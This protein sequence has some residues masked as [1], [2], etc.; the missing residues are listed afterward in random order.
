MKKDT[1]PKT[2]CQCRTPLLITR[3]KAV[4]EALKGEKEGLETIASFKQ[5]F[6]IPDHV[7]SVKSLDNYKRNEEM[8]Y[9]NVHTSNYRN[10]HTSS[11]SSGGVSSGT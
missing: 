11:S 9:R 3:L 1:L 4:L 2:Q 8:N 7:L 5:A 10:V 6:N